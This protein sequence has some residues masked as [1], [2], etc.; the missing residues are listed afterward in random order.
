MRG[1]MPEAE[2]PFVTPRAAWLVE[3]AVLP[4]DC[5]PVEELDIFLFGSTPNPA[6]SITMP[7]ALS[8]ADFSRPVFHFLP[9]FRILF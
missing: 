8:A 3:G 5:K 1:S 4:A 9:A 2:L 6:S 7:Q